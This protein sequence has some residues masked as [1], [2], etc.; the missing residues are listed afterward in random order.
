[1][2]PIIK[3]TRMKCNGELRTLFQ[4]IL[5]ISFQLEPVADGGTV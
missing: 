1:M 3:I 5:V 2:K 4:G